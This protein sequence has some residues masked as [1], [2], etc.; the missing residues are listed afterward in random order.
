MPPGLRIGL[1]VSRTAWPHPACAAR[2]VRA[3]LRSVG[4]TG[5]LS[6]CAGGVETGGK[7]GMVFPV[8]GSWLNAMRAPC[9]SRIATGRCGTR[10][11]RARRRQSG[12]GCRAASWGAGIR[13]RSMS[14]PRRHRA[15]EGRPAHPRGV[16]RHVPHQGSR[17]HDL[18]RPA[19]SPAPR[20]AR[21]L[22]GRTGHGP[23]LARLRADP[24]MGAHHRHRPEQTVPRTGQTD[25]G[26]P[27]TG[28]RSSLPH[29]RSAQSRDTTT[30]GQP[31]CGKA[32][33]VRTGGVL[34][35]RRPARWWTPCF[36]PADPGAKNAGEVQG[37]GQGAER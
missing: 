5:G 18:R 8:S 28:P 9:P 16:A 32:P 31:T 14:R 21:P 2:A 34:A 15:P 25:E 26:R 17:P 24:R 37:A 3:V 27:E 36:R 11:D 22:H 19:R 4:G 33:V 1:P 20:L 13:P 30:T 29:V 35:V 23:R 12:A 6:A 7:C 10:R